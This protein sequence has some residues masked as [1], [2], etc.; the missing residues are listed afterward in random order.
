MLE[1]FPIRFAKEYA[2]AK[3]RQAKII[4]RDFMQHLVLG[5]RQDENATAF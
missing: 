1:P 4:I 5:A 3:W 2:K